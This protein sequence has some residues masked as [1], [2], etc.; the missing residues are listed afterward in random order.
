MLRSLW[1]WTARWRTWVWNALSIVLIAALSALATPEVQAI[2]PDGWLP[3]ALALNAVVN[4]WMRPRR[5]VL[6]DDIEARNSR[7]QR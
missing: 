2:L 3:W 6:A 4:I 5:A 7:S 1:R